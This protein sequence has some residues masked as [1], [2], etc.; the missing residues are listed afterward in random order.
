MGD[1]RLSQRT[2]R[3]IRSLS[4]DSYTSHE[5]NDDNTVAL[6]PSYASARKRLYT[7]VNGITMYENPTYT[8]KFLLFQ[9][10]ASL[11]TP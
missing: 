9:I 2:Y 1:R 4:V 8:G 10:F 11:H 6:D 5:N 7:E 3:S